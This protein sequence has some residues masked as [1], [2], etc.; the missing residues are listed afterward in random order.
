MRE[1]VVANLNQALRA[2]LAK[3]ERVYLLGEDIADPYGGAFKVTRGLSAEFPGRVLSTPISESGIAGVA[4]GLALCGSR[5]VMEVMFGDFIGLCFDQIYN[6]AAKSVSMYGHKVPMHMVIRC[7]V[8][9]NRGYGPT[10]SQSP[11]KHFI[12]IPDLSLWELSPLHDNNVV[13]DRLLGRGEPCI[14]FE[15]K[16]LYGKQMYLDGRISQ[17]LSFDF[18][19]AE[20]NYARV[21]VASPDSCDCVIIAPGGVAE[22]AWTAAAELLLEDEI[23]CQ[24]IVPSRL[25]PFDLEPLLPVLRQARLICV[26]EQGTAGG[27]WGGEIANRIYEKLWGQLRRPVLL[28]SSAAAVIPAA[29]HLERDVLVQT[30]TIYSAVR[31]AFHA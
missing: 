29:P 7:P 25:Y 5:P 30:E 10:H 3:D 26:A 12:G 27:T 18:L 15:D 6:F 2:L 14:F 1:R 9:G 16:V 11:H 31:E 21:F 13:L 20:A 23:S 28:I 24:V 22:Q 17:L 8:G 19:G 4:S